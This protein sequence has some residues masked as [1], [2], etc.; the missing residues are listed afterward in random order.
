[1]KT[2]TSLSI[3]GLT[4]ATITI[5]GFAAEKTDFELRESASKALELRIEER[6]TRLTE[7]ANDLL[8]L[9]HRMGTKLDKSVQRIVSIKDS[10]KSG[11]RVSKTKL[12]LI[13]GLQEAVEKFQRSR[14]SAYK[15]IQKKGSVTQREIQAGELSHYDSHIEKHI[16]QIIQISKSFTQ[17]ANV[18]KYEQDG[19]GLY[20]DGY[21]L[22]ES[23]RIS[24]EY[25]QNRRDR[26]MDKKQKEAVKSALTKS[27]HRCKNLIFNL[28]KQLE[29]EKLDPED[30]KLIQGEIKNHKAMLRL[31]ESQLN[32][33]LLVSK[34]N[35]AE[36]SRDAA[37]ELTKS[38]DALLKDI[39]KDLQL[40]YIKHLQLRSETSNITKL[41]DKLSAQRKWLE[42]H[43]KEPSN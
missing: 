6:E 12:A 7:Q 42:A 2:I 24:D 38:M 9:H 37:I 40:I 43:K 22:Q 39:Q 4:L 10:A 34:P 1:M 5:S 25:R 13:T 17:D 31:R 30:A 33:L 19:S 28:Q 16:D 18:K 26:V 29:S 23:S 41:K 14:D 36:I 15:E 11:Y 21:Y 8:R 3:T 20:Y 27:T 32:D 35:T